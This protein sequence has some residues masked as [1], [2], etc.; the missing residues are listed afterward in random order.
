MLVFVVT[1]LVL[2][3]DVR[4]N[5]LDKLV[6][7]TQDQS[8]NTCSRVS[9]NNGFDK[10]AAQPRQAEIKEV[11]VRVQQ[12]ALQG[13]N[14]YVCGQC[15]LLEHFVVDNSEKSGRVHTVRFTNLSDS[16][17]A[18]THFKPETTDDLYRIFLVRHKIAYFI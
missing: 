17:F 8:G 7:T 16:L 10:R 18:Y 3:L 1:A 15:T 4:A 12:V 13:W 2:V 11:R 14:I 5:L 9:G 6:V